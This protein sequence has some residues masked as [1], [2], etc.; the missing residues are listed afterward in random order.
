MGRG[1]GD[2]DEKVAQGSHGVSWL[3]VEKGALAPLRL[4][5]TALSW[6]FQARRSP[7]VPVPAVRVTRKPKRYV[8]PI[9]SG[10]SPFQTEAFIR[11]PAPAT[12]AGNAFSGTHGPLFADCISVRSMPA[13]AAPTCAVSTAPSCAARGKSFAVNGA[14]SQSVAG[15]ASRSSARGAPPRR[16]RPGSWRARRRFMNAAIDSR[17][18]ESFGQNSVV[19]VQPSVIARFFNQSTFGQKTLASSTS[20]KPAQGAASAGAARVS[21]ATARAMR[22][23][24]DI[25]IPLIQAWS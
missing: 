9:E 24:R 3:T 2:E 22:I 8:L 18:T 23:A 21:A 4:V 14:V 10:T 5:T 6:Q 12:E 25:D 1:T 17:I 19:D 20:V 11:L 15:G 13:A 7:V 16:A